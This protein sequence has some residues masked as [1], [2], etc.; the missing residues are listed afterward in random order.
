NFTQA[1]VDLIV[2]EAQGKG[3]RALL[4]TAKDAAKLSSLN[5]ELP[6]YVA[7]IEIEID[8]QE[9]LR[10]QILKAIGQA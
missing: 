4:T 10:Q 2:R 8:H 1:D 5:F 9:A 3:V 7:E 6:C